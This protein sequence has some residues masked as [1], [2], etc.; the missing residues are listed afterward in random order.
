MEDEIYK[1]KN[2]KSDLMDRSSFSIEM[3]LCQEDLGNECIH[4]ESDIRY[5]MEI[6]YFSIY[7]IETKAELA[8]FILDNDRKEPWIVRDAIKSQF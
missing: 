2:P 3:S 6:L 4:S 1:I 7:S 5:L 8:G